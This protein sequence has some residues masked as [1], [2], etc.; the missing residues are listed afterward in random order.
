MDFS[1]LRIFVHLHLK[2]GNMI[3]FTPTK[4]FRKQLITLLLLS[5]SAFSVYASHIMGGE[6]TWECQGNGQYIFQMK[7]YKDCNGLFPLQGNNADFY[8]DVYGHPSVTQIPMNFVDSIDI[9]PVCNPFGPFISCDSLGAGAAL[10]FI[11]KSAPFLLAGVPPSSGWIFSWGRNCCR[12]AAALNLVNPQTYGITIRSVMYPYGGLDSYP[13]FDSSPQ[14]AQR[15][16]LAI[17]AGYPFSYSHMAIDKNADSLSYHWA[18]PLTHYSP[19]G[20]AGTIVNAAVP[21]Y[22]P[23]YSYTSPFPGTAQNPLNVAAVLDSTDGQITFTSFTFGN[24][25]PV[26]KVTSFRCGIKVSEIFRDI[27]II[28]LNCNSNIPPILV[29]PFFN[30][31]NFDTSVVAGTVLDFNI[32]ANDSGWDPTHSFHQWISF[33]PAGGEFGTNFSDSLSGCENPPCAILTPAPLPVNQMSDTVHFHWRTACHHIFGLSGCDNSTGTKT[34]HYI[35]RVEDDSC[36][37]PGITIKTINITVTANPSALS[38]TESPPP[39]HCVGDTVSLHASTGYPNYLWSTGDTLPD[40]QVT[41]SGD[42]SVAVVSN[43]SCSSSHFS[44]NF[45]PMPH[46]FFS[47]AISGMNVLFTD[48]SSHAFSYHWLFGDG[49]SSTIPNPS[50]TYSGYGYFTVCL[51]VD[52]PCGSDMFCS[53]IFIPDPFSQIIQTSQKGISVLIFP[54]PFSDVATISFPEK[55]KIVLLDISARNVSSCV[56]WE[57]EGDVIKIKNKSLEAGIYFLELTLGCEKVFR[58]M[59]LLK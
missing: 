35:I 29:P 13:C 47:S 19:Q 53:T 11:F 12:N 25:V 23:N 20:V 17:C 24:F 45:I 37:V 30:S 44:V 7:I 48:S 26:V 33:K 36:P 18:E 8:L 3:L 59:I 14:F 9:S 5:F 22:S 42:Y 4:Y 57:K 27:Q 39:T 51:I 52:N 1:S 32:I 55:G 28:L 40:I 16:E 43:D 41:H 10:E 15:P 38:I 56:N 34:Y 2:T 58:K 6:I 50:H 46:S 54:N 21:A 49:D 31:T